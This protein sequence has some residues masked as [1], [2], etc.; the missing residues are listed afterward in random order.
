MKRYLYLWHRWLGIVLCLFMALW[1]VSGMVMLFVGYPKLTPAEHLQ[2]L[3]VLA[4]EDC[5]LALDALLQA[6]GRNEA[7]QRLRLTSVG[8]IPHY[9][10]GYADGSQLTLDARSGQRI[11]RIDAAQALAS[12]RQFAGTAAVQYLRELD[13]DT[14]THSKGLDRHR[15]LHLLALDDAPQRRVYVSG[16]S[17]AVVLDVTANERRWNWLGA[18]LHW[19][20][21]L[22]G[23][24][25]DGWWADIVIYL[26]LAATFLAVLG[27]TVGLL[28]WRFTRRYRNGSHSPYGGFARWHHLGGLLFGLLLIAWIFSGL[29]SMRP[30]QLLA[31]QSQLALQDYQGASLAPAQFALSPTQALARFADAGLAARELEWR[32]LG[33]QGYLVAYGAPGQSRILPMTANAVVLG[34]LPPQVLEQAARRLLPGVNAE[35]EWLQA[36]DF[37]YYQRAEQ[38]MNGYQDKRLPA[39]RVRFADAAG[40]WVHIDP[41]SGA[42]IDQLDENRRSARVLF[43]LLHSWDWQPLLARP[44]LREGLIIAFSL[45]GLLISLSGAVLGWRRLRRSV[46]RRSHPV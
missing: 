9:Q 16:R 39:L 19:L 11:E 43:N 30:W 8:G 25:L 35:F 31:S 22:R 10:L 21:P 38:S 3:P 4:Q 6:S 17:G 28:R 18:W 34:Q 46:R 20:Y 40:S 12:A 36:Y 2:R 42:L 41:Y 33:G 15:P 5:C 13:E 1:F 7:P 27:L 23:G 29:M 44:L 14:W 45:G 24:A 37:N 32:L 26:S